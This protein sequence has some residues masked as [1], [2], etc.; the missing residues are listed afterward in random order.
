MLLQNYQLTF[1]LKLILNW[2]VVIIHTDKN[3]TKLLHI[4]FLKITA[5][6]KQGM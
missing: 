3:I 1:S 4:Q 2:S 5:N 6:D